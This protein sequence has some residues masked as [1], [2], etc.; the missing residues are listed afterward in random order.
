MTSIT[1]MEARLRHA[2]LAGDVGALD[3][4]LADDLVF[5]D[6]TG[7]RLT[8]VDDLAAH[9]SGRLKIT[10][11]EI[12][13]QRIRPSG[14]G[15]VVTLVANFAGSFDGQ[16]FRGRSHIRAFG[17]IQRGVGGSQRRIAR[18]WREHDL[19]GQ[20]HC[21]RSNWARNSVPIRITCARQSGFDKP[22]ATKAR[23]RA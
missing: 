22:V 19:G 23:K 8:K 14:T 2:M 7:R 6:Y 15:A 9:G 11:L 3:T 10:Q 16:A 12:S 13:D 21:A 17:R 1:E 20:F 5:T 4:L 18:P